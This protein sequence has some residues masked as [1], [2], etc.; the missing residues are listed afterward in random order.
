MT[1]NLIIAL[2][3]KNSKNIKQRKETEG[4]LAWPDATMKY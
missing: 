2:A 3:H 1:L 4:T